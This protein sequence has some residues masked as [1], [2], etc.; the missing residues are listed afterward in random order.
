[1]PEFDKADVPNKRKRMDEG[2]ILGHSSKEIGES[3]YQ[4]LITRD[5]TPNNLLHRPEQ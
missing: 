1:M 3:M 4:S 5:T 2:F